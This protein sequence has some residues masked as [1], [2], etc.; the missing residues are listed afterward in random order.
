MAPSSSSSVTPKTTTSKPNVFKRFD[1]VSDH[2]DHHYVNNKKGCGG[3]GGVQK[4]IMQEWKILEK[5]IPNS[6]YVHAY[7]TRIDL[8]R[9]VVVGAS[10]TPY[11]YALF[12]FDIAFYHSLLN[13]WPG[14]GKERWDPSQSMILQVLVLIQGLVLNK[15]PYFNEAGAG[16]RFGCEASRA[17][18][19]KV[20]ILTC[21]TTL[22]FKAF[23][24]SFI[25]GEW[26]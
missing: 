26:S 3:G 14:K 17:Y 12:F 11:H 18:N 23:T 2:S 4:K 16:N 13:T 9:A 25:Y 1:V 15:E 20:F 21:K 6:I 8:L 22:N 19:E 10:G 7:E 24:A 5:H